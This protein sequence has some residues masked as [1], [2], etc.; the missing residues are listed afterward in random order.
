M[1]IYIKKRNVKERKWKESLRV[2]QWHKLYK[3]V[4]NKGDLDIKI[5]GITALSHVA[6]VQVHLI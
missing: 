6:Q 5:I 3:W 2:L 1:R 4:T